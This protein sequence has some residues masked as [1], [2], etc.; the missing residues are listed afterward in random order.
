MRM[1]PAAIYGLGL[2]VLFFA[3][4]QRGFEAGRFFVWAGICE[5]SGFTLVAAL[6]SWGVP[7]LRRRA[8]SA[9]R[10]DMT[11]GPAAWFQWSQAALA[12]TSAILAAWVASDFSYDGV[13]E[14]QAVLGL[15]GR[16]AGCVTALML[17]GATILMAWQ[18]LGLWR[19]VWQYAAMA[20]GVLF[21]S[22]LGW[23]SLEAEAVAG[24]H[25]D[26][27]AERAW[28]L[29]ISTSMMTVMTGF[30]LARV[31]PRGSDW[32][33]RGRRVMPVFAAAALL[34]LAIHLWLSSF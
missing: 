27:W 20:T 28:N 2:C 10:D 1:L 8:I 30:G 25:H 12:T 13:G 15:S 21:T 23:A 7:R 17:I 26:R 24:M 19:R 3:Q 14:G 9:S 31:L 4:L 6:I 22:S 32:V 33:Q 16:W 5:W 11:G 34:T 29:L 18:S